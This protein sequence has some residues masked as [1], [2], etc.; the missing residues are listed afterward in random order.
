MTRATALMAG[1]GRSVGLA[2]DVSAAAQYQRGGNR[3]A[4]DEAW[5]H[6]VADPITTL[7]RMIYPSDDAIRSAYMGSL[8]GIAEHQSDMLTM[9]GYPP[10]P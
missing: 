5:R 7:L 3:P 10:V 9:L 8:A 6:L 4:V 2:P 1:R